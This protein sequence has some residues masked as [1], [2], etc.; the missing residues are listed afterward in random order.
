MACLQVV[1]GGCYLWG[2]MTAA[3]AL[4]SSLGP[5]MICAAFNGLGLALVV[6]VSTSLIAE[7]YPSASRGVGF[8]LM[9]LTGATGGMLGGL[10]ATN[11][12]HYAPL[13]IEGWRFAFLTVAAISV[14][15]GYLVS[16]LAVDPRQPLAGA[17]LTDS[18]I[19]KGAAQES[20]PLLKAHQRLGVDARIQASRGPWPGSW[21]AQIQ[22]AFT[23]MRSD[24]FALELAAY[25]RS[26]RH[27][28]S[29]PTF[30]VIVLQGVA[31]SIPWQAMGFITLWLQLMGFSDM[32][33]SFLMAGLTAGAAVGAL[34][35]GALGDRASRILPN[36]G[37]VFVAQFS[38]LAGLPLT[39]VLLRVLPQRSHGSGADP[40]AYG[41]VLVLLGLSCSW[42]SAA[43]NS[44]LFADIVPE[45]MRTSIYAFDRSFESS[46][47][48]CAAPVVGVLAERVYGFSGGVGGASVPGGL[49]PVQ[50]RLNAQALGSSLLICILFP[51][52]F[53][54]VAFS[55]LHFTYPKD[56][57]RT[58][59]G[60]H[61]RRL[62]D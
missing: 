60:H 29:I 57:N 41:A 18:E 31:G 61:I 28:L 19:G 10:F 53:C 56:R 22:A 47:A 27:L 59:Q 46:L 9:N 58:A 42:C 36:S 8:G 5:A 23:H 43:C 14:A 13:G 7:L 44:P 37:R 2:C 11:V 62:Q 39:Y 33:A 40:V 26:V 3:I 15:T 35:G 32:T 12:G 48:A 4:C 49:S 52:I 25:L 34:F 16:E 51:W 24:K 1:T 30:Q 20:D 50:Q 54:L 6:P 45:D 55:A 21:L 38:V 17:S